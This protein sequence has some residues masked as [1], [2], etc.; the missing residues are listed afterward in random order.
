MPQLRDRR[1][2]LHGAFRI[3]HHGF[4]SLARRRR[5]NCLRICPTLSGSGSRR[6][7]QSYSR[8]QRVAQRLE[9]L[10]GRLGRRPGGRELIPLIFAGIV[11]AARQ[12]GRNRRPLRSELCMPCKQ[13]LVL[14]LRPRLA[15]DRWVE[16]VAPSL[17]AL[18]PGTALAM[19][20][21]C[22]SFFLSWPATS[23]TPSNATMLRSS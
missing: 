1:R 9:W 5:I 6:F 12:T 22:A 4:L 23:G 11:G 2:L 19:S 16:V 18:R 21:H 8:R 15:L 17:A 10:A 14:L 7:G 20:G 3:V 13:D